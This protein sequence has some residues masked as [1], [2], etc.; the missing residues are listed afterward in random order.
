MLYQF[1]TQVKVAMAL[2]ALAGAALLIMG[3]AALAKRGGAPRR[4]RRGAILKAAIGALL[5]ATP[6]IVRKLIEP[7][8]PQIQAFVPGQF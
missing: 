1:P 4:K 7:D 3:V 5:I 8:P 6:P 2:T